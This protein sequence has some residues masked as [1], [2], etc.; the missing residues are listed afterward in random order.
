MLV[1][2]P[3]GWQGAMVTLNILALSGSLRAASAN[4]GLLRL[5]ARLAPAGMHVDVDTKLDRL[6]FYNA[7][8][9]LPESLP[10]VVAAFRDAVGTADALLLGAPEYNFGP[11]GVLKNALDWASRP[12]GQQVLTAKVVSVV[13]SGGKG[14]GAKV[15]AYL[16]S[17]LGLLGNTVVDDPVIAIPL[18]AQRI[19]GDGN[20]DAEIEALMTARLQN[21]A[22]ALNSKVPTTG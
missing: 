15:Q 18:G 14:G 4:T 16:T 8:L 2:S 9:D 21:L 11:T 5:A 10:G 22:A 6:P 3:D 19:G 20:T 7:D 1:V 17:T 12:Q 13:T